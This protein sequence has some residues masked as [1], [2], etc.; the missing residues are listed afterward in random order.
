MKFKKYLSL[1]RHVYSYH[2]DVASLKWWETSGAK[3][4]GH[5]PASHVWS[6]YVWGVRTTGLKDVARL[7]LLKEKGNESN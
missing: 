4:S 7:A 2:I 1:T 6:C 3:R 5:D